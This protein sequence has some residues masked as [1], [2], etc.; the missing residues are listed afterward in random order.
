MLQCT[1]VLATPF[2]FNFATRLS[3]FDPCNFVLL[4]HMSFQTYSIALF[5]PKTDYFSFVLELLCLTNIFINNYVNTLSMKNYLVSKKIFNSLKKIISI[6]EQFNNSIFAHIRCF[7][8]FRN[9]PR[10]KLPTW[11]AWK[12]RFSIFT[13]WW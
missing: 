1:S 3:I 2:V 9:S 4:T 5:S 13:T 11:K 6:I 8:L 7:L 12:E 10:W